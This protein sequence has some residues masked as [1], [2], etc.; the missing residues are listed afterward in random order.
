MEYSPRVT[1]C[2]PCPPPPHS[3]ELVDGGEQNIIAGLCLEW[4]VTEVFSFVT[5]SALAA[6]ALLVGFPLLLFRVAKGD[7]VN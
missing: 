7:Q 3:P 5:G 6:S 4:R 2:G 1:A